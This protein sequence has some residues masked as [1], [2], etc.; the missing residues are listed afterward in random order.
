MTI[1]SN[2]ER[3]PLGLS[4]PSAE[5]LSDN[6]DYTQMPRVESLLVSFSGPVL[7]YR[8]FSLWDGEAFKALV[9]C[10]IQSCNSSVEATLAVGMVTR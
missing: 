4:P 6:C 5:N 2:S 9:P 8:A 10:Q 7:P 3:P 1:K